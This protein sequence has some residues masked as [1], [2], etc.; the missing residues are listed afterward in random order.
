[1][2]QTRILALVTFAFFLAFTAQAQATDLTLDQL[3]KLCRFDSVKDRDNCA[4]YMQGFYDDLQAGEVYLN[5]A[6][7]K[8]IFTVKDQKPIIDWL[9]D[10]NNIKV[11]KREE[12][13]GVIALM[14]YLMRN[15][16]AQI[17][18]SDIGGYIPFD[19][20]VSRCESSI[21]QDSPCKFYSGAVNELEVVRHSMAEKPFLC[22]RNKNGE[23]EELPYLP[24]EEVLAVMQDYLKNNPKARGKSAAGMLV[25]AL[26]SKYPCAADK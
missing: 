7:S 26:K 18:C 5:R 24:D 1:M 13:G 20:L 6:C 16:K 10:P 9:A 22:V 14:S 25:T 21:D 4:H 11:E 3:I 2:M 17:P 19:S 12:I 8:R 23:P 15:D